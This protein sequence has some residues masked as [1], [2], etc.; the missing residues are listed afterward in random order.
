MDKLM[1]MLPQLN[2]DPR[3]ELGYL[4]NN[5]LMELDMSRLEVLLYRL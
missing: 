4:S 2:L 1:S 5:E 3:S